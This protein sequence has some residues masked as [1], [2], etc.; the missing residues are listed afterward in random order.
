MSIIL[1]GT[2]GALVISLLILIIT[3]I[4][5]KTKR[6]ECLNEEIDYRNY[7]IIGITFFIMGMI[8]LVSSDNMGFLGFLGVG[9]IFLTISLKNK[10]K[11]K[12][13]N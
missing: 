6:I 11:W 8:L 3:L 7:F 2:I 1:L 5:V 13:K 9:L 10:D 12:V 4:I